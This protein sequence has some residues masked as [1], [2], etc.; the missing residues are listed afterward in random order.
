MEILF[1]GITHSSSIL[2]KDGGCNEANCNNEKWT[3]W[4]NSSTSDFQQVA[5]DWK[6]L[7]VTAF[8]ALI[9]LGIFY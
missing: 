6:L 1:K 7:T 8:E 4:E 3:P 5:G 2:E 9:S